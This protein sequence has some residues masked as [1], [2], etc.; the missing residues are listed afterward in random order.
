MRLPALLLAT[1]PLAAQS[2]GLRLEAPF[3]KGQNLPQTLLTGTGQ[4]ASGTL[5]TGKGLIATLDRRLVLF[6]PVLRLEATFEGAW[7]RTDGDV[8][9]GTAVQSGRLTQAGLGVGLNAQVWI[10]FSGLG[11]EVGLLQR[12]QR[13]RYEA[14]GASATHTL[15]RPWLRVGARWRLPLPFRPCLVA[16]YQQPFTKDRPVRLASAADFAALLGAQGSGQEFDRLWTFGV[17]W[18]F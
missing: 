2:W 4:L 17:G 9:I 8:R 14:A 6:G 7:L 13:Y 16:S 11:G 15:G 3:P 1:L 10:P 12:A 5:D 18:S